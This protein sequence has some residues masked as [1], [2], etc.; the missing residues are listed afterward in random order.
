MHFFSKLNPEHFKTFVRAAFTMVHQ[1]LPCCVDATSDSY[2][3]E[4]R[5]LAS[6]F[7]RSSDGRHVEQRQP[8]ELGARRVE[9]SCVC[10]YL[11]LNF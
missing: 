4:L 9:G 11:S 10:V 2:A 6:A 5:V 8:G 7:V 1:W 3:L